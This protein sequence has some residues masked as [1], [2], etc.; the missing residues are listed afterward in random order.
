MEI[1]QVADELSYIS[2]VAGVCFAI[3]LV[4][5]VPLF[6][7]EVGCSIY[8]VSDGP[9]CLL[10]HPM[11]FSCRDWRLASYSCALK[12]SLRRGSSEQFGMH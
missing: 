3:T 11:L 5:R 9:L 2:G 8:N 12:R 7:F 1:Y 10:I 4:V 6:L